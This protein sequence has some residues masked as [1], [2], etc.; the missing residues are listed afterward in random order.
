MSTVVDTPAAQSNALTAVDP[1]PSLYL[2]MSA[3]LLQKKNQPAHEQVVKLDRSVFGHPIRRDI[4]HLCVVHHLDSLRQGSA[5]TKTRSEVRGS[6]RK[7]RPQKGSGRARLGNKKSPM[8][9]G[10]SVAFGP[11]PRDFSTKLNRK[12]IQMGMRVALSVKVRE[13]RL[14]V[15]K[16]L[17]WIGYQTRPFNTRLKS[18]GWDAGTLFVTGEQA[19]PR[20]LE[21]ASRNLSGVE[22][23]T[24]QELNVH[25][26]VSW[27]RVILDVQAV[28]ALQTMLTKG[29]APLA[30]DGPVTLAEAVE[31]SQAEASTV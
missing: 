9:R 5:N 27:R 2:T 11:K 14:G 24:V 29:K 10:G 1:S 25:D 23:I 30:I 22:A 3:L 7:I 21:L 6:G 13:Q 16:S 26:L 20:N 19:V 28:E 8:L 4:L 31:T 17:E 12:V 15:V 18:L